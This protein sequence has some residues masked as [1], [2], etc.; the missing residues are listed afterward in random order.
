LELL[1]LLLLLLLELMLKVEMGFL[2]QTPRLR[3]LECNAQSLDHASTVNGT[4]SQSVRM[5]KTS[6]VNE[7]QGHL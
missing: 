6:L 2:R 7:Q 3:L 5:T 4:S 1:L